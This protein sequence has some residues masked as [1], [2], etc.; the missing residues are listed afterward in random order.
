MRYYT[1]VCDSTLVAKALGK[2]QELVWEQRGLSN[3][4]TRMKPDLC[5]KTSDRADTQEN[6]AKL[7][8]P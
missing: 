1:Q 3:A 6:M 5:D 4:L 8:D 2:S 7:I